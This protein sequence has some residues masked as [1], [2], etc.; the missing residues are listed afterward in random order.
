M[1]GK[2]YRSV[3]G[4]EV[5]KASSN[6]LWMTRERTFDAPASCVCHVSWRVIHIS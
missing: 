6:S 4:D 5:V 3:G 1:A 2:K